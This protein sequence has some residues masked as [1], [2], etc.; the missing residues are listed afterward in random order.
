MS[1]PTRNPR[2]TGWYR[3]SAGQTFSLEE[4]RELSDSAWTISSRILAGLL[5]YTGLG[6]LASRWLGHQ[7][8]LMAIGALIGLGLSLTLVFT[9]LARDARAREARRQ[10]QGS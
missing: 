7:A 6:W 3:S 9:G 2:R 5:L 8:A 1:A 10:A 4:S